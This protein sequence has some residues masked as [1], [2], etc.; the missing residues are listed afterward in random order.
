M[1]KSVSARIFIGRP[2]SAIVARE[3][4]RAAL[5]HY[6]K[7]ETLMTHDV[8]YVLAEGLRQDKYW[9]ALIE[10][11]HAALLKKLKGGRK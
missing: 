6:D 7:L 2:K 5:A 8:S 3:L 4:L 9:H 10:Q 1:L 11:Q